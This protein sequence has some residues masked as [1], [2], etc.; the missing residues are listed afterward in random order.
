MLK[1]LLQRAAKWTALLIGLIVCYTAAL[2]LVYLI[3]DQYIEQNV[4]SAIAILEEEGQPDGGGYANYFWH[5]AYG[6]TDNL[7]D[8]VMF[9]GMLKNGR[10]TVQA[11]MRTDYLRYWHGYAVTLRPLCAVLS[12]VNIRFL[13]MM[14]LYA[15]FVLCYYHSRRRLGA[16]AAFFFGAGLMMSFIL[17]APFC[18]QYMTVYLLTLLACY[19]LLRFWEKLRRHLPEFFLILGS[20]VCFFDFLTFPVLALGYPLLLVLLLECRE[21]RPAKT[22]WLHTFGL[23]ALWMAAYAITWLCKAPVGQLLTGENVLADIMEQV[24]FRTTGDWEYVHVSPLDSIRI[25][26]KTFFF[27]MNALCFAVLLAAALVRALR[28]FGGWKSAL[29]HLPVAVVALWPFAWY[30][31]LQ[32]HV[33]L[34]FWMT[35]KQLAVTVFALGAYLCAAARNGLHEKMPA[36]SDE[37]NLQKA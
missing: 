5:S 31:V 28:R 12:I 9:G 6:I 24:A 8:K 1:P 19:L 34:H 7:T 33:R 16:W 29:Y 18:Q 4:N 37:K 23:S 22:L 30:C 14:V 36:E 26:L 17:I 2:L 3:P 32:N 27:S 35:H 11:A 13:N 20:L 25:N 21:N 10:S 15:L